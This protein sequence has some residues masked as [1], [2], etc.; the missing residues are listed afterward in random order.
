MNGLLAAL[1]GTRIVET[2]LLSLSEPDA[3]DRKG[4]A[5]SLVAGLARSTAR[6]AAPPQTALSRYGNL[7]IVR[8]LVGLKTNDLSVR[9]TADAVADVASGLAAAANG[10]ALLD[11][12]A[13]ARDP[14]RSPGIFVA[15]YL[16]ALVNALRV[17]LGVGAAVL[18][19]I[20][21]EWSSECKPWS[22]LP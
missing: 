14:Q 1:S 8:N 22:L 18:F 10:L 19:W 13:N 20:V 9:L 3:P 5:G 15:D 7:R 17:F 12:P 2:H 21:T 4:C 11:D 6:R 16:P